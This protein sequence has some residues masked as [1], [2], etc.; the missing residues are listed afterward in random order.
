MSVCSD[1]MTDTRY[2]I[3]PWGDNFVPTS[4][5]WIEMRNNNEGTT[6]PTLAS[7]SFRLTWLVD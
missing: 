1:L 6:L 4:K 2:S 5:K 3:S 7:H